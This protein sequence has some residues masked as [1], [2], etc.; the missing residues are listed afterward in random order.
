VGLQLE[1]R[2]GEASKRGLTWRIRRQIPALRFRRA[3]ELQ[4]DK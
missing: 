3:E 2:K 4:G 1:F